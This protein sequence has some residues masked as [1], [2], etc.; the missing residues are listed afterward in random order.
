MPLYIS[1]L[2]P[3]L[4]HFKTMRI[5]FRSS[6]SLENIYIYLADIRKK[7]KGL[8]DH[9]LD[10]VNYH[11]SSLSSWSVQ[12]SCWCWGLLQRCKCCLTHGNTLETLSGTASKHLLGEPIVAVLTAKHRFL[13]LLTLFRAPKWVV[14]ASSQREGAHQDAHVLGRTSSASCIFPCTEEDLKPTWLLF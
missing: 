8:C 11:G 4:H 2:T 6:I 5:I 13:S 1:A 9:S 10:K 12:K 3:F 7:I 14:R